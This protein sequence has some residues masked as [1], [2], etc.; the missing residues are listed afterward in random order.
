MNNENN[1]SDGSA[2]GRESILEPIRTAIEA[3]YRAEL[4]SVRDEKETAQRLTA[5]LVSV[6]VD[7]H[8]MLD[9]PLGLGKLAYPYI[10]A[11]ENFTY[12][13]KNRRKPSTVLTAAM[14]EASELCAGLEDGMARVENSIEKGSLY[15][16]V[17]GET[18][19]RELISTYRLAISAERNYVN[20][21][22]DSLQLCYP[23]KPF[24]KDTLEQKVT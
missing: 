18:R 8:R 15:A 6:L 9:F 7:I 5:E 22:R 21:V 2:K 23:Q 20:A 11:W 10:V 17:V 14:M 3:R 24:P 4:Q 16:A 13:L 1:S 12:T 19:L